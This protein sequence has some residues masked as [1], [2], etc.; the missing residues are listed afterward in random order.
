LADLCPPNCVC[1]SASALHVAG[2]RA[3][4]P[5]RRPV[6]LPCFEVTGPSFGPKAVESRIQAYGPGIL[7]TWV[8]QEDDEDPT[9][10]NREITANLHSS[11]ESAECRQCLYREASKSSRA[12]AVPL[13]RAVREAAG[14]FSEFVRGEVR[15]KWLLGPDW[16]LSFGMCP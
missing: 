1:C 15:E 3:R 7:P 13:E 5:A 14:C 9:D 4:P 11:E 16:P 8:W 2:V 10:H 12:P 6:S